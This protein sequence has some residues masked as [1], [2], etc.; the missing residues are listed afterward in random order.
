MNYHHW[1]IPQKRNL[2]IPI[3]VYRWWNPLS[4]IAPETH[5]GILSSYCEDEVYLDTP[6][7][8]MLFSRKTGERIY[9]NPWYIATI[10]PKDIEQLIL[11]SRGS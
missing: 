9:K 10:D 5:T 3:T 7:G 8:G 11:Q 2:N 6:A 1:V 4:W